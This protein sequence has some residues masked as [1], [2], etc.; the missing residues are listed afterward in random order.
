MPTPEQV[1][2]DLADMPYMF[3]ETGDNFTDNDGDMNSIRH[4]SPLS[5]CHRSIQDQLDGLTLWHWTTVR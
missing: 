3:D 2:V 5:V 1:S 4:P